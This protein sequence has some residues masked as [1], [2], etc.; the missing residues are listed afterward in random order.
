MA[1]ARQ[2]LPAEGRATPEEDD[3]VQ[4]RP[5]SRIDTLVTTVQRNIAHGMPWR[6][7]RR[8]VKNSGI[9]IPDY[10]PHGD[11]AS[12]LLLAVWA[13]ESSRTASTVRALDDSTQQHVLAALQVD[14]S[15]TV[16]LQDAYINSVLKLCQESCWAL[17]D[18]NLS[19]DLLSVARRA[20]RG[21]LALLSRV[22][23]QTSHQ[24]SSSWTGGASSS[25]SV[26]GLTAPSLTTHSTGSAA[27]R[28]AL[29]TLSQ[30]QART[31]QPGA[32]AQLAAAL[33]SDESRC[34]EAL[35][36][37]TGRTSSSIDVLLKY[38]MGSRKHLGGNRWKRARKGPQES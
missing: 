18:P 35:L 32:R 12:K 28:G 27:R 13:A 2:H 1:R 31:R 8:L 26:G 7:A 3:E 16:P 22:Q 17:G 11:V 21:A 38:G 24:H 10:T 5:Q 34:L 37:S 33:S 4:I 14:S 23:A 25:A 19:H 15:W 30:V 9:P 29:A 20:G 36:T 6:D